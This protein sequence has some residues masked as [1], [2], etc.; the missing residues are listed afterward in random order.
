LR[1]HG[2]STIDLKFVENYYSNNVEHLGEPAKTNSKK[3]TTTIFEV[4][5]FTRVDL[6]W[7]NFK[8]NK[9][10]FQCNISLRNVLFPDY[11]IPIKLKKSQIIR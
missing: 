9:I 7:N 6:M 3:I 1:F 10:P 11:E 4:I 8:M 2:Q 5:I